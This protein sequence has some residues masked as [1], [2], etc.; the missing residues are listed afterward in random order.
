MSLTGVPASAC[1]SAMEICSSVYLLRRIERSVLL[2]Y[3]RGSGQTETYFLTV[4]RRG[5]I[6]GVK[7]TNSAVRYCQLPIASHH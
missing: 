4:S 1:L 5:P 3:P 2:P 7:T 6:V